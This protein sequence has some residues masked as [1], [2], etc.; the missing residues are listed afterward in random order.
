MIAGALGPLIFL[1]SHEQIRTFKDL[2]RERTIKYA[3]HD[4]LEGRP[5]IQHTGR[6]LDTVTLTV[7]LE[8]MFA[9]DPAPDIAINALL[10]V[11]ELAAEQPLVLGANY[12]SLWFLE[13]ASVKHIMYHQGM[14]WRATVD[15]S[16]IEYN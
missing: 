5:R 14:T 13:K 3:K 4:V 8:R 7:V 11:A 9:F 6:D 12:F 16:L 2:V 10:L 15:L 1:V